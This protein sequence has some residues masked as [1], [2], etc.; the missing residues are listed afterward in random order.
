[1]KTY[2]SLLRKWQHRATIVPARTRAN[3]NFSDANLERLHSVN[4]SCVMS[5]S[6]AVDLDS[7]DTT[8]AWVG[9]GPPDFWLA[10]VWPPQFFLNFLFKFVWLT[11][12]IDNFRPAIFYTMI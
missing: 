10:P 4:V 5:P 12:T 6:D 9:H 7:G 11:Y 3:K 2:H 8:G 1:M